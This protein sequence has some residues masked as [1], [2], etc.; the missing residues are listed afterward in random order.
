[1]ITLESLQDNAPSFLFFEMK[2][3]MEASI[4]QPFVYRFFQ[5]L[6][7]GQLLL[8]MLDKCIVPD[9]IREKKLT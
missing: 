7:N 3:K 9:F 6:M 2:K 4:G 1:M 8:R 5:N